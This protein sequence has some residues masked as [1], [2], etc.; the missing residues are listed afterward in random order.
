MFNFNLGN[1]PTKFMI[2]LGGYAEYALS[3]SSEISVGGV[4]TIPP[5]TLG[6]DKFGYG[7]ALGLGVK[8]NG[9]FL[10][11]ARSFYDLKTSNNKSI[12]STIGIGYMF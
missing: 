1:S 12:V 6:D 3:A 11:E 10:I 8:I 7:A 9:S 2:N 5:V 4:K